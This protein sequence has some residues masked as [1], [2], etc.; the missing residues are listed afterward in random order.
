MVNG[1]QQKH[2][3]K[4]CFT[5]SQTNNYH[6]LIINVKPIVHKVQN[7]LPAVLSH[8]FG[9]RKSKLTVEQFS[10]S[11]FLQ[12]VKR[13]IYEIYLKTHHLCQ[14]GSDHTALTPITAVCFKKEKL[15]LPN[16]N[17]LWLIAW[18]CYCQWPSTVVVFQTY[19]CTLLVNMSLYRQSFGTMVY[20]KV[21]MFQ[22]RKYNNNSSSKNNYL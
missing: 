14:T 22:T 4:N 7:L 9:H 3:T 17:S 13:D 16:R 20:I 12:R 5:V 1:R 8:M 6:S 21:F 15:Q 10:R 2:V 11:I 18:F 19:L